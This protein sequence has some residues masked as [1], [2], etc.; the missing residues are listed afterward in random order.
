MFLLLGF[1]LML[2]ANASFASYHPPY[3]Y[4]SLQSFSV[5]LPIGKRTGL[6]DPDTRQ[7]TIPP[8]YLSV[9]R[10]GNFFIAFLEDGRL[11]LL[12]AGTGAPLFA[13][14]SF[15][16]IG[17]VES[18]YSL[19]DAISFRQGDRWG[20]FNVKGEVGEFAPVNILYAAQFL[21][22][23]S[24]TGTWAEVEFEKGKWKSIALTS[25]YPDRHSPKDMYF[26]EIKALRVGYS[27]LVKSPQGKWG[28]LLG[29]SLDI[30]CKY[31]QIYFEKERDSY[32]GRY[33]DNKGFITLDFYSSIEQPVNNHIRGLESFVYQGDSGDFYTHSIGKAKKNGK[34]G[35]LNNLGQWIVQPKYEDIL[36]IDSLIQSD[37]VPAKKNG[38]WGGVDL[39][40]NWVLAPTY[41]DA[42]AISSYSVAYQQND[43]KW[44]ALSWHPSDKYIT[45]VAPFIFDDIS[46]DDALIVKSQ[47]KWGIYQHKTFPIIKEGW[48]VPAE[49]DEIIRTSA[50]FPYINL[51]KGEQWYVFNYNVEVMSSESYQ[52]VE[53]FVNLFGYRDDEAT[54][55]VK[56][57]NKWGYLA[58][59]FSWRIPAIFDEI[60]SFKPMVSNSSEASSKVIGEESFALAREGA[61]WGL[62]DSHGKWLVKPTFS[63]KPRVFSY[64]GFIPGKEETVVDNSHTYKIPVRDQ[65]VYRIN[66]YFYGE[67]GELLDCYPNAIKKGEEALVA[68][69]WKQAKT[70]FEAALKFI[71]SDPAA[72]YGLK[73]AL[74]KQ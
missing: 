24:E 34:W 18:I 74:E 37:F 4:S 33:I 63:H 67:K 20:F 58:S 66:D 31:G 14:Q 48:L 29:G 39:K 70:Y 59:D 13:P 25:E 49:Y 64:L 21:S 56:Q 2:F 27:S 12:D 65:I 52:I 16:E 6:L 73:R 60:D 17:F 61:Y 54:A 9:Q 15:D 5:D 32:I 72:Q 3:G 71:P 44:G 62:I 50:D 28:I 55:K 51:H 40:G 1:W 19:E 8:K 38:L 10:K 22:I 43:N 30:P 47:G 36:P 35:V 53:R 57:N 26:S 42:K 45:A 69:N 11:T 7:W 23:F 41:K 46:D 68:N